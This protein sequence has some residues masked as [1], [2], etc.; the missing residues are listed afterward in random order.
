MAE[1]NSTCEHLIH[2][3]GCALDRSECSLFYS[4]LCKHYWLKRAE[5]EAVK[6]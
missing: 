6:E 1:K 2:S 5:R 4:Q 3:C